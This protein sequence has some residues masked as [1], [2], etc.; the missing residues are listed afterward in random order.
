MLGT[1]KAQGDGEFISNC[2]TVT[3]YNPEVLINEDGCVARGDYKWTKKQISQVGS[4][5]Q[6]ITI[7]IM[8]TSLWVLH[9][10]W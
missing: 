5:E 2:A 10:T 9:K 1:T 7:V 3:H 6:I 8:I 4:P